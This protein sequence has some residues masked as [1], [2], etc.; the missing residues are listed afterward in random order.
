MENMKLH[1]RMPALFAVPFVLFS[2]A[3]CQD[4][5]GLQSNP[6]MAHDTVEVAAPSANEP[7]AT[8]FDVKVQ[9]LSIGGARHPE[10]AEHVDEWDIAVRVRDGVLQ[11]VPAGALGS[12]LR[13][14]I[15]QPITGTGFH[16]LA[17]APPSREFLTD[18]GVPVQEGALYV[19]RS[20][21]RSVFGACVQYSKIEVISLQLEPVRITLRIASNANCYDQRL[22][23]AS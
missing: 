16:D 6:I 1:T 7:V 20:R 9:G 2:L 22:P 5:V 18:E 17:A 10:R 19:V 12:T 13:P 21:E 23:T 4:P 11:F 8:A 3:A 15:T 14:G